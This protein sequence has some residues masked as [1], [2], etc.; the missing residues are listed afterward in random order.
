M[1]TV[2]QVS[3]LTSV[4]VRTLHYYDSIGLL[5]PASVTEAGYRMYDDASLFRLQ[6][7][8]MLRQLQFSLGEIKEIIDCPEFDEHEALKQQIKL[9]ELKRKH[10]D[11]LISF[12]REIEAKGVR[13]MDFNAFDTSEFS[14]YKAQAK[15]KWKKT[16][17]YEEYEK[18]AA[19][20]SD[21]DNNRFAKEMM[22]I[23][24]EFGKLK[25]L[26]PKDN[27][28][29]KKVSDL[30]SY[31]SENFYTCTNEILM[32]LGQMY[33]CDERFKK[34]IDAAGGEG[35]AEFVKR[36]ITAFCKR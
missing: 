10:I 20:H 5:K 29:F 17:A 2:K 34:N 23:F 32:Q 9:L 8:L 36:A 28:V 31:I 7:I 14:K 24:S 27:K 18:K 21:A 19:F 4:S 33:V 35:T 1:L 30:Q 6:S 3:K 15:A 13:N 26:S 16:K 11:E 22:G 12:A 25:N